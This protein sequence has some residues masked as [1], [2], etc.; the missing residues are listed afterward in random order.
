MTVADQISPNET[1]KGL[2]RTIEVQGEGKEKT[3]IRIAQGSNITPLGNGVYAIDDQK[4]FIQLGSSLFPN[5]E[6][7]LNQRV[8]MLPAKEKI[9]YQLIW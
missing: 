5:I 1:G 3:W 7:Y 8:L 4:Y 2:T 9:Q 6:T